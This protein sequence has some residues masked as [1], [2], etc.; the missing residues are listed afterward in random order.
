MV[1][2]KVT[3]VN[4]KSGDLHMGVSPLIDHFQVSLISQTS[5]GL[6]CHRS[7]RRRGGRELLLS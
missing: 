7:G 5:R 2:H 3:R 6:Y 4:K 1:L